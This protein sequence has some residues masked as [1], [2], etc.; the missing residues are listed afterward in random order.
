MDHGSKDHAITHVR[1]SKQKYLFADL[2]LR[3][4]EVVPV[5]EAG[6]VPLPLVQVVGRRKRVEPEQKICCRTLEH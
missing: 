5:P 6:V 2:H 1:K 4:F 3:M